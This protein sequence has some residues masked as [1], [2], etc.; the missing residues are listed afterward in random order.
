MRRSMLRPTEIPPAAVTPGNH[1]GVHLGHRALVD[2]AKAR[3]EAM[4][5]RTVGMFFDPHPTRV[6]SPERAPTLLTMPERR[7]ALLREAGCDE[8]VVK[9]FDA[10]FASTS[11]RV[12]VEEIL[13]RACNARCVVTGPDF[14]FGRGRAGNIETLRA[15]GEEYG[16]EVVVV[17]PA[18][19]QGEPSSSTRIRQAL[20]EGE[21]DSA[22]SMLT[23]LHETEGRVVHGDHRGRALGF[24]TANLEVD[25]TLLPKDGVYL[26]AVRDVTAARSYFGVANLGSR[27]TVGAGRSVEVHVFDFAGDLYDHRLRVGYAARLR[28]ERRFPSVDA[29]REQ[30]SRDVDAARRALADE[31]FQRDPQRLRR[32]L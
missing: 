4:G 24:P 6:L 15:L 7:A 20:V 23:R 18:L 12:F 30:I 26:V 32:W 5:L 31:T 16:F 22:A 21:V 25:A 1:D 8:V 29:L 14:Q 27:P 13:V 9:S 11:P 3:A 10:E 19:Y 28:D 17:P 2:A